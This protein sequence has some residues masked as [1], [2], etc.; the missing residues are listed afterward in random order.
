MFRAKPSKSFPSICH[1][2]LVSNSSVVQQIPLFINEFHSNKLNLSQEIWIFN[3]FSWRLWLLCTIST[4]L[5]NV[6]KGIFIL[7][8]KSTSPGIKVFHVSMTLLYHSHLTA[9]E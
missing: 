9:T 4:N 7:D 5:S 8:K 3:P 2:P 1:K 6:T